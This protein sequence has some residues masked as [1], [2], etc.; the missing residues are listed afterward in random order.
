M[1]LAALPPLAIKV[2]ILVIVFG[3]GLNAA[4]SDVTYLLRHPGSLLRAVLSMFVVTPLLVAVL[5]VL[6]KPQ[7]VVAI[8]LLAL[9][10]SPV[11]PIL[12]RKLV[13][14]GG[15][16]PYVGG[17]LVAMSLLSI[18]AVPLAVAFFSGFF[19]REAALP[20]AVVAKQVGLSV[21]LPLALG[22]LVRQFAP[23]LAGRVARGVGLVGT[24]LMVAGAL[25]LVYAQWPLMRGLVS[26]G[27]A[28]AVALLVALGLLVGHLLGGPDENDRTV[29]ALST[30]TRHPGIAMAVT[31]AAGAQAKEE[32]AVILL[33]LVVG[34]LV[35]LPYVKWRRRVAP[36]A[37]L[38][39]ARR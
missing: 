37:A 15:D 22:M 35:S 36:P 38:P 1:D 14:A 7:P 8:A 21:L 34:G 13:K 25:P 10:V 11:P 39:A 27:A 5:I 4:W 6:F 32:L 26:D 23:A 29:L 2:S 16:V 20:P 12:P 18:V 31:V 19:G 17:L 30:A 28:F 33:Y 3:L 9:S 24:V